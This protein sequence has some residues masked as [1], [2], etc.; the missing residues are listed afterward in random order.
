VEEKDEDKEE[1][2]AAVSAAAEVAPL[3]VLAGRMRVRR[4]RASRSRAAS[5]KFN[6]AA[7]VSIRQH[8]SADHIKKNIRLGELLAGSFVHLVLEHGYAVLHA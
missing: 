7:Q 1:A 3:E 2:A 5:S 6:A 4:K 8:T